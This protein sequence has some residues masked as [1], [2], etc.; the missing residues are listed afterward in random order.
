MVLLSEEGDDGCWAAVKETAS[1]CS[2]SAIWIT[3]E[4][5]SFRLGL[6]R[7]GAWS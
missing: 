2:R 6:F 7:E 3:G 1:C 4:S 5:A